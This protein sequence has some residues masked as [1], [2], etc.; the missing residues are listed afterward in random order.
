MPR[1]DPLADPRAAPRDA[2]EFFIGSADPEILIAALDNPE[3]HES[4]LCRLLERKDAPAELLRRVAQRHEWIRSYPVKLRLARH[5]HTPRLIALACVRQ[6]FLFDLARVSL[7]PSA[8]AEV[9]R[10]AED[11]V[12]NRLAQLP[13]GQKI[14]LA[15]Q[16]PPRVAAALL[17]EG[18]PSTLAHVLENA[19]LNEAQITRVL[20]RADLPARVVNAISRHPKWSNSPHVRIALLRHPLT[21]LA[22]IMAFLPD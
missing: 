22:R 13:V 1:R 3:L 8:L 19:H 9:R 20:A 14:T 16:G 15:K 7:L 2:L 17:A 12:L 21:P 6:L 10:V 5:P 18:L 4:L 11:L